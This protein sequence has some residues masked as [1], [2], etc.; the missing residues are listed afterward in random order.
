ML[1]FL[2]TIVLVTIGIV[3]AEQCRRNPENCQ[4][5]FMTK[6]GWTRSVF[7]LK[8]L[9]RPDEAREA[10]IQDGGLRRKLLIEWYIQII[11]LFVLGL[12]QLWE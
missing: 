8:Y 7:A 12:L 4:N 5:L 9:G 2:I 10:I 3:I 6:Q 1:E 11:V